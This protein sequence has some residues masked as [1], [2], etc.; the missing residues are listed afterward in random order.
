[1]EIEKAK[2]GKSPHFDGMEIGRNFFDYFYNTWCTNPDGLINV[3]TMSSILK[4][5]SEKYEGEQFVLKLKEL[6]QMGLNFSDIKYDILY[7]GSR[8]VQIL[9]NGTLNTG[10]APASPFSQVLTIIYM[11]EKAT[12]KWILNNSILII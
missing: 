3:I 11:G 6:Q 4:F 10:R 12:S 2:G 9:V 7:N 5:N 8:Q 1:M